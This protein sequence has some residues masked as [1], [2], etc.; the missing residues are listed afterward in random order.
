MPMRYA[1]R[2]DVLNQLRLDPG[3]AA[4]TAAIARVERLEHAIADTIDARVGHGFGV[5][6][7]PE[8]RAIDHW[9]ATG[10][11]V[12]NTPARSVTSVSVGGITLSADSWEVRHVDG[13]GLIW[14]IASTGTGTVWSWYGASPVMITGIWADQP[15]ADVPND[16]REAVT[17]IAVDEYRTRNASPAGEIGPDGLI[18]QV[19]NPWRF[20][21]VESA[22]ERHRV[23][24]MLV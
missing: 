19:R 8:A 23:V 7:A 14:A 13:D 22:I 20:S 17:F 11:F 15:V 12:F 21:M 9:R 4:D 2:D 10:T 16:I 5:A 24:R 1:H 6:P 18:V 3:I